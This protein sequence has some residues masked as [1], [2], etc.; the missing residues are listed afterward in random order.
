MLEICKMITMSTGHISMK[1]NGLL[2]KVADHNSRVLG[3]Y[4]PSFVVF[5][6]DVFGYFIYLGALYGD[7]DEYDPL[8]G[9][10]RDIFKLAVKNNCLWLC[11]DCDGPIVDGLTI[12]EWEEE[13][14]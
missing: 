9:D 7:V 10:L 2:R 12:Y 6:K 11:L 14:E 5:K 1:T 13:E 8:P 3:K 4:I